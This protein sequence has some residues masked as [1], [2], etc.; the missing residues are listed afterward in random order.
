MQQESFIAVYDWMLRDLGLNCRETV[1][2]AVIY[3]FSVRGGGYTGGQTYLAQR[4]KTTRQTVNLTL[5]KLTEMGLVLKRDIVK[6]G[7]RFCE[8]KINPA[9]LPAPAENR[10]D[11][12]PPAEGTPREEW[13]TQG[14]TV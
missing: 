14:A 11:P 8:Y 5:R 9:A 10:P 6:H 4:L 3:S 1:L 13:M 2:Y 7:V 12:A